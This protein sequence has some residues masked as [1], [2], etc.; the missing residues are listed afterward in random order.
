[1]IN[2]P[3]LAVHWRRIREKFR[4]PNDVIQLAV[5]GSQHQRISQKRE[6]SEGE[7]IEPML[8][9]RQLAA[10]EKVYVRPKYRPRVVYLRQICLRVKAYEMVKAYETDVSSGG[11]K[12][13]YRDP[14]QIKGC[15][16]DAHICIL[17]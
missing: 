10:G 3:L 16:R 1:M 9:P 12:C 8:R 4:S 11:M 15:K 7:T 5:V 14:F 17:Y 13:C 6:R 2:S